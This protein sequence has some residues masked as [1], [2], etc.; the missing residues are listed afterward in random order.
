M[1]MNEV[2]GLIVYKINIQHDIIHDHGFMIQIMIF[3]H[4]NGLKFIK[5]NK[6]QKKSQKIF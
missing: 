6:K 1:H 3:E 5:S 4:N 2:L